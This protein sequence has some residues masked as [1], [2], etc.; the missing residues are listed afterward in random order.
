MNA[1]KAVAVLVVLAI[2]GYSFYTIAKESLP[3]NFSEMPMEIESSGSI[4][5]SFD[6]MCMY[7][8]AP[9]ITI[10]SH[11]PQDVKDVTIDFFLGS[12]DNKYYVGTYNAG[13]IA[14]NGKTVLE[15][16]SLTNVLSE[17]GKVKI[18]MLVLL[19][20]IPTLDDGH[21][22]MSFPICFKLSFKYMEWGG[23]NF[24]GFKGFDF[25]GWGSN[26]LVDMSITLRN[27]TNVSGVNVSAPVVE[28]TKASMT[29]TITD[30]MIKDAV[31][32]LI[33]EYDD[34]IGGYTPGDEIV[35]KTSNS[36]SEAQFSV[37]YEDGKVSF[38]VDGSDGKNAAEVLEEIFAKDGNVSFELP[39]TEIK[40]SIDNKEQL[41]AVV[42]AL[43]IF[44]NGKLPEGSGG[45]P[46]IPG[47]GLIP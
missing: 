43:D 9:Q 46:S 24:M 37:S 8:E 23:V 42:N 22:G 14:A 30:G 16:S 20:Y 3:D 6:N 26:D 45:F 21:G 18:P 25:L 27:E 19:S 28:G 34:I 5:T 2:V 15:P 40:F 32:D 13:T 10:T 38:S 39:G 31:N 35:F 41:D 29:S 44:Y 17:D 47:G 33:E 1:G 4:T 12:G 11:L 7:L 36:G